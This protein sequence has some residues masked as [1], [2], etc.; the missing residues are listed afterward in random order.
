MNVYKKWLLKV[1]AAFVIL[2]CL[3]AMPITVFNYIADPLWLFQHKNEWN[4]VQ[5]GFNERQQKVNKLKYGEEKYDALLL[6]SSRSTYINQH[7]FED[8][9]VFNFAVSSMYVEEYKG[10]ID[11]AKK[12]NGKPFEYIFLGLDFFATNKYRELAEEKP[13]FY[14]EQADS[15]LYRV[16]STASFDTLKKSISVYQSSKKNKPVFIDHRF[17]NRE[18]VAMP[19]P[20][21][22]QLRQAR[23]E[24]NIYQFFQNNE[25]YEYDPKVIKMLNQLKV[26]NPK[27]KFIVYTTPVTLPRLVIEMQNEEYMQGYEHWLEDLTETFGTVHHFMDINEITR[28]LPNFIDSH[29]FTPDAGT[30]IVNSIWNERN[31]YSDF[32]VTLNKDNAEA[33]ISK[34]KKEIK[35]AETD[36]YDYLAPI[37]L[38][39]S[40]SFLPQNFEPFSADKWL[41]QVSPMKLLGKEGEF[42]VT[43][44]RTGGMVLKP[45]NENPESRTAIQAGFSLTDMDIPASE[46]VTF[47]VSLK[48]KASNPG[49]VQLFIQDQ[50]NGQWERK[51]Y[52]TIPD[53]DTSRSFKVSKKIRKDAENVMIGI[54]WKNADSDDQWLQIDTADIY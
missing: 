30:K 34:I 20:V 19:F 16:K 25:P 51:A 12:I 43:E 15:Y 23:I 18:N 47:I 40:Y 8:L 26:E 39:S 50:V 29:H 3:F 22:S 46:E 14:T 13:E 37:G 21:D 7:D 33:E 24:T 4:D 44:G 54:H 48:G 41:N 49:D 5:Q 32:G 1:L 17:Y 38:Q 28:H 52:N 27:T 10:Y 42:Q 9:K 36:A 6:G 2:G 53:E 31:R 11:Y 45:K 35:E